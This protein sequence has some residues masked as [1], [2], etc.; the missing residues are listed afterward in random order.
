MSLFGFMWRWSYVAV[1]LDVK[2][3]VSEQQI[4]KSAHSGM[5]KTTSEQPPLTSYV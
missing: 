2:E 4:C 5:E 3:T 1:H